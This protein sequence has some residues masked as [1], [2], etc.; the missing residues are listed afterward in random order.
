[1]TPKI[2]IHGKIKPGFPVYLMEDGKA[3]TTNKNL[4]STKFPYTIGLIVKGP[5]LKLNH[6]AER[7]L[8][9]AA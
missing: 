9:L 4:A 8:Q 7:A 2:K 1:M 6:M 5:T 3:V